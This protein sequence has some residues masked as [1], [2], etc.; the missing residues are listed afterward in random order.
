MG[1][2][3]P[4]LTFF[5]VALFKQKN[6]LWPRHPPKWSR[7]KRVWRTMFLKIFHP[8]SP[9][10]CRAISISPKKWR[11]KTRHNSKNTQ[12]VY[13]TKSTIGCVIWPKSWTSLLTKEFPITLFAIMYF[14]V[15]V[16][17]L[18]TV[19]IDIMWLLKC[20]MVQS[21]SLKKGQSW[22]CFYQT[23]YC[24][25]FDFDF[26]LWTLIFEHFVLEE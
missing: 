21:F 8:Q 15:L 26:Q 6:H 14:T 9:E 12:Q 1:C 25:S 22:A 5:F 19:D 7:L 18:Y 13:F 2:F 4:V 10:G 17:G 20:W 11:A 23:M 3:S 16:R 24:M